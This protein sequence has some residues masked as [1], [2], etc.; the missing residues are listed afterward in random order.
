MPAMVEKYSKE[1]LI[2]ALATPI[3]EG[4]DRGFT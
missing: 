1:G 3:E 4:E 2:L